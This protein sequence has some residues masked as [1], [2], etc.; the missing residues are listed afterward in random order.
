MPKEF[1]EANKA[2]EFLKMKGFYTMEKLSDKEVMSDE[3]FKKINFCFKTTKP[4]VDFLNRQS[5]MINE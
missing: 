1:D 3:T 2:S 5:K 4:L